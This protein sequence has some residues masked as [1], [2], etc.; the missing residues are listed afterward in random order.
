MLSPKSLL[1]LRQISRSELGGI[2]EMV[3]DGGG[4]E[5]GE[6][7]NTLRG[8]SATLIGAEDRNAAHD[9]FTIYTLAL[10]RK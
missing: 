1:A 10:F 8:L 6:R 2:D 4:V 9:R 3:E 7:E 5:G